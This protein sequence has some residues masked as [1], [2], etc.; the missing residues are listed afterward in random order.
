[1][2]I[3]SVA[4]SDSVED[5]AEWGPEALRLESD[6]PGGPGRLAWGADRQGVSERLKGLL[7]Y[8]IASKSPLIK[9]WTVIFC[10]LRKET[11]LLINL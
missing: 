5:R 11:L 3:F 1:M 8:F 7:Q 4:E 9:R 2:F 10:V 6:K